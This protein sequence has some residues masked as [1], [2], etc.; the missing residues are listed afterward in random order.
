MLVITAARLLLEKI[1]SN[2]IIK[3]DIISYFP[4]IHKEY[5]KY[6]FFKKSILENITMFNT[7]SI[8]DISKSL[9]I[10]CDT[11]PMGH[12]CGMLLS[13]NIIDNILN[14][15]K[16]HNKKTIIIHP[17]P[18]GYLLNNYLVKQLYK[19]DH[20]IFICS[21]YEGIDSRIISKFNIFEISIG[22]YIL[23]DGDTSSIVLYNAIIRDRIVK[24]KAKNNESL[25]NNLLE[26]DQFTHP[27]IYN[28]YIIPKVLRSG[29]HKQINNWQKI[30]SIH[31][32][33]EK[34]EDLYKI[35]I[36][37]YLN[38][39]KMEKIKILRYAP[40]LSGNLHIGNTKIMF[41]NYLIHKSYS[42]SLFIL[43][44]DDS[45]YKNNF[46]ESLQNIS[47]TTNILNI[48]FNKIVFQSSHFK[49]IE[50]YIDILKK[51]NFTYYCNCNSYNQC[52]CVNK[53]YKEGVLFLNTKLI[54]KNDQYIEI[55][56]FFYGKI[57]FN[58]E[59]MY[60][61][62]ISRSDGT[63]L[64]N[65][66]TVISD[67]IDN[68]NFIVRGNDHILNT[69]KQIVIY[70]AIGFNIPEYA[71]I[72]LVLVNKTKM[73]KS[74]NNSICIVDLIKLGYTLDAI[75]IYLLILSG[76]DELII[77]YNNIII[78]N[79]LS[80]INNKSNQNFDIKKLENINF[81]I[82]N[83]KNIYDMFILF[84]TISNLKVPNVQNLSYIINKLK[85]RHKNLKNLYLEL[86]LFDIDINHEYH[87]LNNILTNDDIDKLKN[88]VNIDDIY[89]LSDSKIRFI[90]TG[91]ELGI[92]IKEIKNIISNNLIIKR[93]NYLLSFKIN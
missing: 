70:R 34:R 15:I 59:E 43:R 64:Y 71:H 38:E 48:N 6:S 93:I 54:L 14:K 4:N 24:E 92:S 53:D 68:I 63:P 88:L 85:Y 74:S 67:I 39:K 16:I 5:I 78:D 91:K 10:N 40:S 33:I 47:L 46:F 76:V 87:G 83:S 1:Q 27:V 79:L 36:S 13:V 73:S 26:Y 22:D 89:Q 2:I 66:I 52:E 42:N 29:N 45:D 9:N 31:K 75:K 30:N 56:D 81:K 51:N 41:I 20:F 57:R 8:L 84:C 77:D 35:Y 12:N 50:K 23:F 18:S 17:S 3:F 86:N 82:I 69:W 44:Y 61:I 11:K 7:H 32:T 72:P 62:A 58:A 49:Y 28:E 90:I 21:R 65:F 25:N 37:K 60:N 55:N 80:K 19:F